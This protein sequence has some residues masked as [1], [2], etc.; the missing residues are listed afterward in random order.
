MSNDVPRRNRLDLFTPAEKA[1]YDVVQA[2]EAVGADTR[3]TRAVIL[4]GEARDLVADFVDGVPDRGD[5]RENA[6]RAAFAEIAKY[7]RDEHLEHFAK[8][9][10]GLLSLGAAPNGGPAK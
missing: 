7:L 9:V 4:L 5:A 2:V 10:E 6:R 8:M 3:L 1:I